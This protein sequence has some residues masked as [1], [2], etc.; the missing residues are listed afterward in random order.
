[1]LSMRHENVG[2][3]EQRF[4]PVSRRSYDSMT[5]NLLK[6]RKRMK[7]YECVV[8]LGRVI[9]AKKAV[10][11]N[12]CTGTLAVFQLFTDK[13]NFFINFLRRNIIRMWEPPTVGIIHC[14]ATAR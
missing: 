6:T 8:E 11:L 1:M 12:P 9:V 10:F 4:Y 13:N 14:Q 5:N 2:L 7:I 3:L